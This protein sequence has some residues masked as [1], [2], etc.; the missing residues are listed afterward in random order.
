[1]SDIGADQ[2]YSLHEQ[3]KVAAQQKEPRRGQ[4][5]EQRPFYKP[6]EEFVESTRENMTYFLVT[7]F[8]IVVAFAWN[9]AFK[10]LIEEYF[11]VAQ[12]GVW[13][14]FLYAIIITI[15]LV[16][17]TAVALKYIGDKKDKNREKD[18]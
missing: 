16:I 7:A 5:T 1:M 15:L 11:P 14:Q 10:A 18:L 12:N 6:S 3:N 2:Q 13:P 8:G 9:D 4:A 17:I